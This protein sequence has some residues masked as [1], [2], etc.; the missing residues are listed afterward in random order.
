MLRKPRPRYFRGMR[1]LLFSLLIPAVGH[2]CSAQSGDVHPAPKWMFED[3]RELSTSSTTKVT[4][5]DSVIRDENSTARV[6]V[7]VADMRKEHYVL[8]V[9]N[10]ASTGLVGD[11]SSMVAELPLVQRDSVM[12]RMRRVLEE[13]Y[14]PMQERGSRFKVDRSG[15]LIGSL[16][17]DK[18][19]EDLKPQLLEGV[20][21]LQSLAREDKR[22]TAQVIEARREHLTDSMY[23]A[24]V[25]WQEKGILTLIAPFAFTFPG[26]G[27]V[28]QPDKLSLSDLP[29]FKNLG[30]LP[31]MTELGLDEQTGTT[32][33]A[34]VVTTAD[35][36]ALLKAALAND[37]KSKWKKQDLSVVQ[38]QVYTIDRNSGWVTH[39]TTELRARL[40]SISIRRN[41]V[42]EL[43]TVKQ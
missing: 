14:A 38:E 15:K 29:E 25:H 30:E 6:R 34:R 32:I 5:G 16:D 10:L 37:P 42:S 7:K 24:F 43:V 20:K 18:D 2:T 8:S 1:K 36:D 13:T 21:Q 39:A 33:I 27:S 26:S 12:K 41:Q 23:T 31:A 17:T 35:G 9:R 4:H 19:M 3:V 40:G 11:L 28:R 22:N